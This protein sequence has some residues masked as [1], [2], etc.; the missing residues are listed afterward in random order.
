LP[1]V[2]GGSAIQFLRYEMARIPKLS[3]P[4]IGNSREI[5]GAWRSEIGRQDRLPHDQ[6]A[7]L[8]AGMAGEKFFSCGGPPQTR[9]SSGREQKNDARLVGGG[10]K[11]GLKFAQAGESCKGRLTCRC[12]GRSPEIHAREQ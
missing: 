1:R 12:F 10:V 2:R 3:G 9:C 7:E 5:A 11:E 8:C 6:N 4:L